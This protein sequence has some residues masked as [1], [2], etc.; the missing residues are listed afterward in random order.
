MEGLCNSSSLQMWMWRVILMHTEGVCGKYFNISRLIARPFCFLS[1]V[2]FP[3]LHL[4][5]VSQGWGDLD[6]IHSDQ[7]APHWSCCR[8]WMGQP[9]G[10]AWDPLEIFD[11]EGIIRECADSADRSVFYSISED[12]IHL[13]NHD[14]VLFFSLC[15]GHWSCWRH[16][17]GRESLSTFNNNSISLL[18]HLRSEKMDIPTPGKFPRSF[19]SQASSEERWKE[20]VRVTD[21]VRS[22]WSLQLL[23]RCR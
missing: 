20:L 23:D 2:K 19:P 9:S 8:E 13:K 22:D 17:P 10:E 6:Q 14:V 16:S 4:V 12:I 11:C 5:T 3:Q 15:W 7:C 1:R 21:L 18:F